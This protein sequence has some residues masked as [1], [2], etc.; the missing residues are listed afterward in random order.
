MN[1]ILK[2]KHRRL[3]ADRFIPA[4]SNAGFYS[5]IAIKNVGDA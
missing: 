3:L 1:H 4:F 5:K 2:H